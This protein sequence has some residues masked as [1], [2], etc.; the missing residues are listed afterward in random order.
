MIQSEYKPGSTRAILY[1]YIAVLVRDGAPVD[2]PAIRFKKFAPMKHKAVKEVINEI[3][4]R[5]FPLRRFLLNSKPAGGF[6]L[7]L[8]KPE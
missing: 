3:R 6:V 8:V 5:H 7:S 4:H 1:H 2:I